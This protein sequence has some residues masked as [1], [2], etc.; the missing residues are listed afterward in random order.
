MAPA[1]AA[2]YGE[3]MVRIDKPSPADQ[4]DAMVRR[5]CERFGYRLDV[6]GWARRTYDIYQGD[7]RDVVRRL[8]RV[9]SFATTNGEVRV[10]EESALPFAQ[11]LGQEIEQ[12]FGIREA[13]IVRE[14]PGA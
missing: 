12:A 1:A 14:R 11:A 8:A 4:L 10:F 7:P 6:E 9:E 13:V 3:S 2:L 5:L